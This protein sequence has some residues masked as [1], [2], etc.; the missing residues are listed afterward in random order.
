MRVNMSFGENIEDL[1]A[2]FQRLVQKATSD[3]ED[4]LESLRDLEDSVLDGNP[5]TSH[6]AVE[7][8]RQSLMPIDSRLEDLQTL[9]K[10]YQSALTQLLAAAS[11]PPSQAPAPQQ[12]APP[13]QS[14]D[15]LLDMASDSTAYDFGGTD[16]EK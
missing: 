10:G 3:M 16:E 11:A 8:V 13:Q 6:Q 4:V 9:L 15:E 12:A 1:P 7:E 14:V 2:E 5:Y